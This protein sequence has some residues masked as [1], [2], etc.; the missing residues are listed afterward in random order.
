MG[1]YNGDRFLSQAVD[2]ILEQSYRDLEFIIINDGSTDLSASILDSY[3]RADPR[4]RVYHQKNRGLIETLNCGC[5]L[6]RGKY[7]A[8]MDA[9][10]IAVRDRLMW[11]LEFMEMHPDV[12][13]LG[14]A[15]EFINETNEALRI[16]RYPL[17]DREIQRSLLDSNVLWHP[18][19]FL[20]KTVFDAVGGYRKVVDAEDYDMWLRIADRF[21]LANL[22]AVVLKYRIHPGQVSVGRCKTQAFGATAA[23]AAARIRRNGGSDPL[24]LAGEI[25]PTL[26]AELGV[27]EAIQ[28]T[29]LARGYLSCFRNMCQ[30]G[31]YDP[32]WKML[33]LLRSPEVEHAEKWVI[34]DAHLW[35]ARLYFSQKEFGRSVFSI[36]RALAIRPALLARPLKLLLLWLVATF[37][38]RFKGS[39]KV[40]LPVVR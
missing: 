34:A 4:V 32:A 20:R 17:R 27:S 33:E 22:Y 2:S 28:Q 10:D 21:Q 40:T 15:V 3:S 9:D 26:L 7:I 12:G 23:Q 16:A 11:Q 19:I 6:S 13:V 25:T 24:D 39:K 5:K 1:V 35:A 37:Q 31:E 18:S 29:A 14:G 36:G 8:R 30:A 38:A